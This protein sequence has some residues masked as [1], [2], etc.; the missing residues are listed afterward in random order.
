MAI[1][2][3]QASVLLRVRWEDFG[4]KKASLQ[5]V[6]DLSILVR[7]VT[8]NINDYTQA[9]TFS[10][11]VDYKNFPF[12]PRAIRSCGVT[13]FMQNVSSVSSKIQPS[14]DNAV[15]MGFADEESI[16]FDDSKRTVKMEGRDYTGLL[17]DRKYPKGTLNVEHRLDVV[18]K[19]ILA[20]L[21]E[22]KDIALA[23]RVLTLGGEQLPT[24]SKFWGEKDKLG[25]RINVSSDRSYWDVIQDIVGRAGLIAYMELDKLVLSKP[26][27]LYDKKKTKIF[28]YGKNVSNLEMKR[29]IGRIKGFNLVVR[30]LDL[31]KKEVIEAKIPAEASSSW[32]KETGIPNVEVKLQTLKPDGTPAEG[33]GKDAKP[34]PYMSFRLPDV[35][36]KAHLIRIGQELYEEISRQQIDGNLETKEMEIPDGTIEAGKISGVERFDILKIRVGTPIKV[37][38]DQGDLKGMS[39]FRDIAERVNFLIRRGYKQEVAA[40][41]AETMGRYDS[42]FFTK[43]ATLSMDADSG[44]SC[45][46]EFVNFIEIPKSLAGGGQA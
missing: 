30:S 26:R 41:F 23:N 8:V 10:L 44:F 33:D 19:E 46:V 39:R 17:I 13:V 18:I 21:P 27:V 3:P 22:T 34:A 43:A 31:S 35:A 36:N 20:S 15:F 14:G 29:K 25:S 9:D 42:V 1:Y 32:S 11:E 45:K 38:I 4:D 16:R 28:V 6:Y 37:E 12:D 7:N 24:L 40:A 5:K 2:Y